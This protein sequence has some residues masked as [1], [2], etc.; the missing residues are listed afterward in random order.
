MTDS[1]KYVYDTYGKLRTQTNA[2]VQVTNFGYD[3][4]AQSIT[5][6]SN[7]NIETEFDVGPDKQRNVSRYYVNNNLQT[8]RYYNGNYEKEV[9]S[10]SGTKEYDYIYSPEGLVAIVVNVN[11][12]KAITKYY[13]HTDHL[14]SLRVLTK[15]DKSIQTRCYYDA[16]GKRELV[17]GSNITNRGFTMHEHLDEF[18]LI[19]MNARL[20]DPLLGRFLSL[21]QHVQMPNFTQ[22]FNRYS[23]C[24]NNP[25]IYTDPD[26]ELWWLVPVIAAAIFATGNTIAHAIRGDINNFWDFGKY[27][28]QGA[29]TGFALG[30]TWQF[31]P[32]IPI[33]G[34]GIQTGMTIYAGTQVVAGVAGMVGGAINDGLSG[35]GR[36]GKIFLG[37]F[38]LDEN[39]PLEGIW[40]GYTRHTWEFIQQTGGHIQSQWRNST[41][42]V[43]DVEYFGGAT[44]SINANASEQTGNAWGSFININDPY[45]NRTKGYMRD[46]KGR[47]TPTYDPFYMHEYGHTFDSRLFGI[48]YLLAIGIPSAIAHSNDNKYGWTE[49]RANRHAKRYF[50]NYLDLKWDRTAPNLPPYRN[51]NPIEYYYPTRR[52]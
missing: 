25:L 24:L 50:K 5:Y 19:N 6:Q 14:G 29:V 44:W 15:A 4:V 45:Y 37:N 22:S 32:L 34:Q 1:I 30:C 13:A 36:A 27:F 40:Q 26:G 21:D 41:G 7:G 3:A 2:R 35:L 9:T 16:W 49:I 33:F 11:T 23:Y 52:R 47:F 51:R 43:T 48:S 42:D 46:E 18:N 12:G 38:Y 10:G 28:L 39:K 20:Y 17:T 8:T 31:A